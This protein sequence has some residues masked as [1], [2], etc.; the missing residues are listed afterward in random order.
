[1]KK[2]FQ[3]LLITIMIAGCAAK[4]NKGKFLLT[5]EIKNVPDQNIYLEQLY[6]S[7]KN[8]EVVDTA[9][10]KNGKFTV[11]ASAPEQGLY[12]LRLE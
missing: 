4:E 7:Q 12:R 5:G 9:E 3:G 1:M 10:I 6:F 2:V 8:P 11:T